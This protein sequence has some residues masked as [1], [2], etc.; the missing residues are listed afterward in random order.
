[1]TFTDFRVSFAPTPPLTCLYTTDLFKDYASVRSSHL[2]LH[3]PLPPA[4]VVYGCSLWILS[5]PSARLAVKSLHISAKFFIISRASPT[6]LP[7]REA[8]QLSKWPMA[9]RPRLPPFEV[10]TST[11]T[12]NFGLLHISSDFRVVFGGV[13]LFKPVSL[14]SSF[15]FRCAPSL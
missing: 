15:Q 1:M 10:Q 6:M 13:S 9:M 3:W 7:G 5:V 14:H 4:N 11:L 8:E 2:L 12:R